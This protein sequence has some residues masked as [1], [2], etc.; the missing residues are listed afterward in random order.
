MR[1]YSRCAC[2]PTRDGDQYVEALEDVHLLDAPAVDE[3]VDLPLAAAVQQHQPALGTHQQVHTCTH[4]RHTHTY[5]SNG[6]HLQMLHRVAET[7]PMTLTIDHGDLH[8]RKMF[9]HVTKVLRCTGWYC[10]V[11]YSEA[12]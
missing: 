1:F 9:M 4:A 8:T 5:I 6:A 7:G 3:R 11:I 12:L 10:L 2:S